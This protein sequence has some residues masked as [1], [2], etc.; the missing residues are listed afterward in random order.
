MVCKGKGIWLFF[1]IV[2]D[3]HWSHIFDSLLLFEKRRLSLMYRQR[4]L[5]DC[6]TY[7]FQCAVLLNPEINI[8]MLEALIIEESFVSSSR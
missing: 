6:Q 5:F 7:I 1:S 8:S 2:K 4:Q 3:T